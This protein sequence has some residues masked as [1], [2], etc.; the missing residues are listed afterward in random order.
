MGVKTCLWSD[1]EYKHCLGQVNKKKN[2]SLI[3]CFRIFGEEVCV[4][5][6]VLYR[7]RRSV[8]FIFHFAEMRI[9]MSIRY[10]NTLFGFFLSNAI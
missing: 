5:G 2:N 1:L 9:A 4:F 7:N 8:N 6:V 3:Y 10:K